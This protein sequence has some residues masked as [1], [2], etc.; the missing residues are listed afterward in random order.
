MTCF[1]LSPWPCDQL[2]PSI[3]VKWLHLQQLSVTYTRAWL[4]TH[5]TIHANTPA[6]FQSKLVHVHKPHLWISVVSSWCCDWETDNHPSN[7]EATEGSDYE[8]IWKSCLSEWKIKTNKGWKR[9]AGRWK[10]RQRTQRRWNRHMDTH[11]DRLHAMCSAVTVPNTHTYITLHLQPQ[12]PVSHDWW[13]TPSCLFLCHLNRARTSY[14]HHTLSAIS[15][16]G[17]AVCLCLIGYVTLLT[18]LSVCGAI[19]AIWQASKLRPEKSLPVYLTRQ[20]SHFLRKAAGLHA[21]STN[22]PVVNLTCL[23]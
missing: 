22:T 9:L 18:K 4:H 21:Q 2:C 17:T 19:V 14:C 10:E 6:G 11:Q 13:Q 1:L 7:H 20:Q 23:Q 12:L 15:E 3:P 8:C 16:F 5:T